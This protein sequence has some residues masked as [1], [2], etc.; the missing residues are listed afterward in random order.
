[1]IFAS[2]AFS[3]A[4]VTTERVR[5]IASQRPAS[6]SSRHAGG[7]R[8]LFEMDRAALASREAQAS[9]QVKTRIGAS[10][11]VT[12]RKMRSTVS[13]ASRRVALDGASQ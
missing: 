7:R 13:S 5:R 10:H 8:K 6:A 3:S 11:T 9:S 4:P 1:M 12:Q 2:R